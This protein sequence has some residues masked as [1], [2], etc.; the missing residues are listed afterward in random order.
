MKYAVTFG[1]RIISRT[2]DTFEEAYQFWI[3]FHL[4][5]PR[6]AD[7]PRKKMRIVELRA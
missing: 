4:G 6:R 7:V 5:C 1:R 2:F 3:D